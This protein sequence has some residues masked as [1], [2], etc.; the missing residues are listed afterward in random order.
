M[1]IPSCF[2]RD[3][4]VTIQ[5]EVFREAFLLAFSKNP[6]FTVPN[7]IFMAIYVHREASNCSGT[8]QLHLFL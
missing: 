8:E 7:C 5:K 2:K 4:F 3:L 6:G 1:R